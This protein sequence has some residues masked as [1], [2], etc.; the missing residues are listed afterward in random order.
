[1]SKLLRQP[2]MLSGEFVTRKPVIWAGVEF[3]I[4][5]EFPWEEV[6]CTERRCRQLYESGHIIN[7]PKKPKVVEVPDE[8]GDDSDTEDKTEAKRRRA[9]ERKRR[10]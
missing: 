1:M 7:K 8:D 6:G 10:K 3:K 2:F 4:G 9:A 5:D